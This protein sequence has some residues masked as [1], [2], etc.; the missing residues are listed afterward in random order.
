MVGPFA[1]PLP[2]IAAGVVESLLGLSKLGALYERRQGG[3]FVAE[4]LRLLRI[5][6]HVDGDVDEIPERGPV[7][8]V[9]N[10]PSGGLDGLA[11]AHLVQRR[12][13]DVKILANHLLTRIPE[14][15]ERII[16]VNTFSMTGRE[17]AAAL[18]AARRW[19]ADGGALIVFPAGEVSNA[20]RSAGRSVD[21]VWKRGV[22]KLIDWSDA[23]VVPSYIHARPSWLLRLSGCIH[24]RL[25]TALLVR[26]LIARR[27]QSVRVSI[28]TA[29]PAA[30]TRD[31]ASPDARLS[32][33]R[34]RTYALEHQAAAVERVARPAIPL[35]RA[36]SPDVL[37]AELHELPPD[38]LLL[39][40]GAYEVYCSAAAEIPAVLRE[41]GRLREA[42]FRLVDEGTGR[43]RDLDDFDRS[44]RHLFV[45]D[46]EARCIVGAYRLGFTDRLAATRKPG[47]LYTR[48][49]FQFGRAFVSE[50]GDAI[51]L[52]RSFVRAEYQRESN[53]L[54]L[55]WRGIGAVVAREPRYR[56]LFGA[57]SISANYHPLTRQ[58]LVRLLEAGSHASPLASY[59]RPRRPLPAGADATRLVQ[60]HAVTSVAAAERFVRELEGR[61]LPVLLRQ[62]L[63]L[64]ARLL[65]FSVDPGF[66][67][68]LDGLVLV[69][70][71]DVSPTLLQRYLG[72]DSAAAFLRHHA[73]AHHRLP[74]S[75]TDREP[76]RA[77]H[78][79]PLTGQHLST[80]SMH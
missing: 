31:F 68:V 5:Q 17:N 15:R 54:L 14:L 71:L 47:V 34:A 60:S 16:G 13:P 22:L 41:I 36:E 80:V 23:A 39:R 28:G 62:Y 64:N 79:A 55:L 29:V 43:E 37:S 7:V 77:A 9:A 44:Y 69:D 66:S 40:S 27:G 32:Y 75:R 56:L 50:L 26:D 20:A 35:A 46:A 1:L 25:R 65:G 61:G 58:L 63:K 67:D 24:P 11:L 78:P 33:L 70:L 8:V 18:R 38:A 30:R 12:R 72:R 74:T 42:T 53:A 76:V 3:D 21:G 4:A 48:T 59:V 6:V 2:R 73:A 51:E 10:H 49:L 45:W 52:G 57:V 19:L